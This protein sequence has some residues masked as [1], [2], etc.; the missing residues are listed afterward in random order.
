ML[1]VLE[2]LGRFFVRAG[3]IGD[4]K[5]PLVIEARAHRAQEDIGVRDELDAEAVRQRE[6]LPGQVDLRGLKRGG[7]LKEEYG[8]ERGEALVHKSESCSARR[9]KATATLNRPSDTLAIKNVWRTR[10]GTHLTFLCRT[11]ISHTHPSPRPSP[12]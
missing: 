8:D 5:P 6:R 10:T 3:R 4:V 12:H 7:A 2:L 9:F 11:P 1:G